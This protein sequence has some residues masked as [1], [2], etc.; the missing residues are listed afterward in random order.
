MHFYETIVRIYLR[1]SYSLSKWWTIICKTIHIL[2]SLR[3]GSKKIINRRIDHI[4]HTTIIWFA[5]K[6]YPLENFTRKLKARKIFIFFFFPGQFRRWWSPP[7]PYDVI[8]LFFVMSHRWWRRSSYATQK[9]FILAFL[10]SSINE[11]RVFP[12]ILFA[13]EE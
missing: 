12:H 2:S 8:S 10:L 3:R 13:F 9:L 7:L 6:N 5:H 11:S 1:G 4:T